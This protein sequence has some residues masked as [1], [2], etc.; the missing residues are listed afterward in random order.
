VA[1]LPSPEHLRCPVAPPGAGVDRV[2]P[3]APVEVGVVALTD[4]NARLPFLA[5]SCSRQTLSNRLALSCRPRSYRHWTPMGP[6]QG[7][8]NMM[9]NLSGASTMSTDPSFLVSHK[10][11]P[12][13][14]CATFWLLNA[15][16]VAFVTI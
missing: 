8:N 12:N 15:I 11:H 6:R 4:A 9:P 2:E 3:F 14:S 10:C 16:Q 7:S 5:R 13:S 1:L